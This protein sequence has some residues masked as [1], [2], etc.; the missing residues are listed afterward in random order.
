[1][2]LTR[3]DWDQLLIAQDADVRLEAVQQEGIL[4]ITFPALDALVGFGGNESGHKDLWAHTKQ[5]VIQ[6][7]P[8]VLYRW[9]ALFHD[10]GKP[11]SFT[12]VEGKIAFHHHEEASARI[13][14]QV[15]RESELF[16]PAEVNEI[17]FVIRHLGHV[18]AYESDWTD[19][20]VRRLTRE[21]GVHLDAVFAVARADCTTAR[22]EKR[23]RQLKRTHEIRTRI[24]TLAVLD[25]V[26]PALPTGLGDVL[27]QRL[28]MRP[29]PEFGVIMRGLKARVDA[30]ELPRNADFEI[31]L[32]TLRP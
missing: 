2:P 6:T 17:A 5:V 30:G 3:H 4:G 13:F 21:L 31:Y 16:Q 27:M 15:A 23:Q 10:V 20:A 1:M 19:S 32:A 11:Q 9:M 29:G 25:A 28:G 14:K 22:P 12:R 7:V 24:D 26:P 8:Q 18:E